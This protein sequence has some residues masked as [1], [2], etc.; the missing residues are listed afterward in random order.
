MA[1]ERPTK[2]TVAD[3]ADA[4]YDPYYSLRVAANYTDLSPHTLREATKDPERPLPCYSLP[5]KLLI[6]RSE[7]DSWLEQYFRKVRPPA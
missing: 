3:L 7:L 5:R 1:T 2:I 6:R 4:T